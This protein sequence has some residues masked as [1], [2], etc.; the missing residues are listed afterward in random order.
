MTIVYLYLFCFFIFIIFAL[1]L[2]GFE[3]M[4]YCS[5]IPCY[6]LVCHLVAHYVIAMYI[7]GHSD[8]A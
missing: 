7:S 3:P 1:S 8:A 2:A 5:A 4:N 6:N